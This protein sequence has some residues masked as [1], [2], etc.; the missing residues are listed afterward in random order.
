MDEIDPLAGFFSCSRCAGS[1]RLRDL[2]ALGDAGL[3][4]DSRSGSSVR[5]DKWTLELRHCT[6][7]TAL[8]AMAVTRHGQCFPKLQAARKPGTL[9]RIDDCSE[10]TLEQ[11]LRRINGHSRHVESDSD[12]LRSLVKLLS[13]HEYSRPQTLSF[14]TP[15][16]TERKDPCSAHSTTVTWPQPPHMRTTAQYEA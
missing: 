11:F 6:G 10:P 4:R 2:G 7:A 16:R 15:P 3:D 14:G 1:P 12:C 13:H 5:T 8:S 9:K